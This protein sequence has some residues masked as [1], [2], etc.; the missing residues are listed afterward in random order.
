MAFVLSLSVTCFFVGRWTVE[1]WK[2]WNSDQ[3]VGIAY[4]ACMRVLAPE[5]Q[6]KCVY[7]ARKHPSVSCEA[8]E[9]WELVQPSQV[10][11]RMQTITRK[12]DCVV[13]HFDRFL[14][15]LRSCL[16]VASG[17]RRDFRGLPKTELPGFPS[18]TSPRSCGANLSVARTAQHRSSST[19]TEPF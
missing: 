6:G 2:D 10:M 19:N 17:G 3:Q 7:P 8:F 14:G 5:I 4:H 13:L 16:L 18:T 11:L 15:S 9:Y 12:L 1:A